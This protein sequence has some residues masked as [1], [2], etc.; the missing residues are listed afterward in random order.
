MEEQFLAVPVAAAAAEDRSAFLRRV[1]A[2]TFGGLLL[3]AIVSVLSTIF[4]VPFVFRGGTWAVLGVVYGSFLLA[5]TVARNMVYGNAKVAGFLLGAMMQG[6]ALGFL[7]LITI[8]SSNQIQQGLQII[9]YCL[10]MV[11]LSVAAMLMYVTIERHEFSLLRAGLSMA[12][13]PMLG[14]MA[15]QLVFPIGGTFGIVIAAVFL[16]VS[17]GAMLYRLNFVVHE[18]GTNMVME[19]AYELTLGIVVFFWNLL[20]FVNRLRRR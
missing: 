20:S 16:L 3:T 6:I 7:L 19:G 13:L 1:A 8:A 18:M 5:Q 2:L 12:F 9:L 4:V 17:V 10:A 14:L 15:L 11:I